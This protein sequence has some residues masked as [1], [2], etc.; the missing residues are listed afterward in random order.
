MKN[1]K[2]NK[3]KGFDA[4]SMRCPYCGGSVI[5]RSADGIYIDNRENAMLYVCSHYPRCGAYV[6]THKGTNIPVGT[7]ADAKL[8]QLRKTA[9]QYFDKLHMSGLMSKNDAYKW[10]ADVI[11]APLSEAHIGYLGEYY[12]NQVIE[13]AKNLL[14][15]AA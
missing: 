15:K 13:K 11:S 12:C 2:R 1:K 8:R 5:F 4:G 14:D 7:L 9:H 10:L 3:R 6:R